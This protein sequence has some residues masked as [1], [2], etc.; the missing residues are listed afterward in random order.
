MDYFAAQLETEDYLR[1]AGVPFTILRPTAF[2]EIW[3][4]IVLDPIPT[5]GR[6]RIFGPGTTRFN[7]VAVENVA[8]VAVMTLDRED[9]VGAASLTAVAQAARASS[10][11]AAS[12]LLSQMT[13]KPWRSRVPL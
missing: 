10:S 3:A 4:A 12:S 11:S 1:G 5:S 9:A 7:L 2:M 6:A 8:E 13:E